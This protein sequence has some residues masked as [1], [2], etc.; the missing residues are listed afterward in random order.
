MA[1]DFYF[2]LVL[3]ICCSAGIDLLPAAPEIPMGIVVDRKLRFL[4]VSVTVL[5]KEIL[6][7]CGA[8]IDKLAAWQSPG[9]RSQI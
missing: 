6:C 9:E 5:P 8:G 1:D 4:L 2:F 7:A 3:Y